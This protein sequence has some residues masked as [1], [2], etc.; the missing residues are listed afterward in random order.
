[1]DFM[2]G[3]INGFSHPAPPSYTTESA[4]IDEA[5][6]RT[7]PTNL[8]LALLKGA[9]PLFPDLKIVIMSATPNVDMFLNYFS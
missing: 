3:C 2:M 8:L 4:I 1:M 6:E 9:L 5:H 7:I